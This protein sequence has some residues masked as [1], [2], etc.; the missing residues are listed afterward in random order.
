MPTY[1]NSSTTS[2]QVRNAN[3]QIVIVSPNESVETLKILGTGWT[4]TADTPF[5]NPT[6]AHDILEFTGIETISHPIDVAAKSIEVFNRIDSNGNVSL[7]WQSSSNLPV[8]ALLL[9]GRSVEADIKGELDTLVC[10]ST[11]DAVVEVR[12]LKKR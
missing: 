1:T 2:K 9:P 12:V 11:D 6:I 4:K 3:G 7:Y 10:V 8:F 5:A